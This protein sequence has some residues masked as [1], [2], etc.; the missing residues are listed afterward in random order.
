MRLKIPRLKIGSYFQRDD[1][2][3]FTLGQRRVP[4]QKVS[5]PSQDKCILPIPFCVTSTVGVIPI[6]NL[7]ERPLL[8]KQGQEITRAIK[9]EFTGDD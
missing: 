3:Q 8:Y 7:S 9:C 4:R 1:F 2:Y 6:Q 5:D